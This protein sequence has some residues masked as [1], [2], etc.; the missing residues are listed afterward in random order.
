MC[1]DIP[2]TT[3][4]PACRALPKAASACGA[5]ISVWESASKA[6]RSPRESQDVKRF[7]YAISEFSCG[8]YHC[9]IILSPK[10]S[11]PLRQK[12]RGGCPSHYRQETETPDTLQPWLEWWCVLQADAAKTGGSRSPDREDITDQMS[13][14]TIWQVDGD[15]WR[16][17]ARFV[18]SFSMVC[19]YGIDER[20]SWR[21]SATPD[22]RDGGLHDQE[23]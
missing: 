3:T 6:T 16:H 1:L 22:K 12:Y 5:A 15:S 7:E 14:Q 2:S 4:W 8:A 20:P 18:R 23:T 17:H 11:R 21:P 10:I 19:D 9:D 13:R